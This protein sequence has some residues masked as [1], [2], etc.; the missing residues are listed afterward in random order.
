MGLF[1]ICNDYWQMGLLAFKPQFKFHS[2]PTR[3]S[4]LSPATLRPAAIGWSASQQPLGYEFVQAETTGGAGGVKYSST[5]YIATPQHISVWTSV[6]ISGLTWWLL[7]K[8][9]FNE[10]VNY[11][12][13]Y[14]NEIIRPGALPNAR[15]CRTFVT[16]SVL[17]GR[18]SWR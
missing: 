17:S 6:L 10:W 2:K 13:P 9:H 4:T 8:C 7:W 18:A 12:P 14:F 3:P 5:W 1:V 11:R 16:N 15:C